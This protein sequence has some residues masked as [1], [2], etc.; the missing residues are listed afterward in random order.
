M[1][2]LSH[3][4]HLVPVSGGLE[5]RCLYGDPWRIDYERAGRGEIPYHVVLSGSAVVE[6]SS[7]P[8]QRLGAGDIVLLPSGGA[9]TMHDGSGAT[10]VP[11]RER[12][13]LNFTI[14]ENG[15]S[16]ERLNMLCG[17]FSFEPAQGRLLRENLPPRLVVHTRAKGLSPAAAEAGANLA[18]LVALMRAEADGDGLGGRAMM[19]AFSTALFALALRF[20]SLSE[21]APVGILALAGHPRLAPA[22]A[23]MFREPG[24]SWTLPDLARLCN[25]SRATLARHFQES[26]GRSANDLLSDIRMTIAAQELRTSASTGA[27]AEAVGYQ[28]DA[29]FQRAFKQRMGMTPAQ[30]R[31]QAP[32]PG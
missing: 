1:D 21:G 18:G 2:W 7:S 22:L 30:W 28:S 5:F 23:A 6:D 12:P 32:M 16:D 15:G 26:F 19:N 17:R 8:P 10:P 3:L 24:K 11:S 20:A 25:M 9:H 14:S 29:A 27:V 31:R 4:L 13:G